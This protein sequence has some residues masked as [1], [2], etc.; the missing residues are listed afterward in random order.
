MTHVITGDLIELLP[1]LDELPA[2]ILTSPPYRQQRD[3]GG[4][5]FDESRALPVIA[6]AVPDG[7]LLAWHV[8][9]PCEGGF[10]TRDGHR[11]LDIFEECGL[12]L[13]ETLAVEAT[14]LPPRRNWRRR[15]LRRS[16]SHVYV[17]TRRMPHHVAWPAD[18]PVK[19]GGG[20]SA[21]SVRE[22]DG[23]LSRIEASRDPAELMLRSQVWR[24]S[25]GWNHTTPYRRAHEHP[26]I[27]SYR[28]ALDLVSS[29]SMPGDLVF[30]PMCG[31]GTTLLAA[32]DSGRRWQGVEIHAP[33]AQ[34]ARELL[35]E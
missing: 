5:G 6:A 35:D 34:L 24:L 22:R 18:V 33:Y 7:G 21:R 29:L 28:L 10:M 1:S 31:S 3:Y 8:G 14:G 11:H 2:L 26:A 19:Y 15:R 16:L 25:S 20:G 32:R 27:M 30:D 13:Y 17:L 4:H 9:A 12:R 23:S